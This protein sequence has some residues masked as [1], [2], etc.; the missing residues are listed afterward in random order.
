MNQDSVKLENSTKEANNKKI[1]SLSLAIGFMLLIFII[2]VCILIFKPAL[3]KD[4]V[5]TQ[6][7]INTSYFD[8]QQEWSKSEGVSSL[9][10]NNLLG[11]SEQ[12]SNFSKCTLYTYD[13]NFGIYSSPNTKSVLN[14]YLNGLVQAEVLPETEF[15]VD[16]DQ[17]VA[18]QV[19]HDCIGSNCLS[20]F[21]NNIEKNTNETFAA[22]C[23]QN[24]NICKDLLTSISFNF[25]L[26]YSTDSSKITNKENT[27]TET[28]L[29]LS[30]K[31]ISVPERIYTRIPQFYKDAGIFTQNSNQNIKVYPALITFETCNPLDFRQKFRVQRYT[32]T[33]EAGSDPSY[34]Q[35]DGKDNTGFFLQYYI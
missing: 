30:V 13:N 28:T 4:N 23:V 9:S 10:P 3:E 7:N 6:D 29:C 20:V 12:D 31:N 27:I 1:L 35:T 25:R 15:C 22:A 32:W 24:N 14:D 17:I 18:Q 19:T 16:R 21:G 5:P 8:G 26:Y 11:A 34:V 33:S 2:C